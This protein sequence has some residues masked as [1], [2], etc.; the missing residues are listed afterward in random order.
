MARRRKR[1]HLNKGRI[2]A[3]LAIVVVIAAGVFFVTTR[4]GRTSYASVNKSMGEYMV[5]ANDDLLGK[6]TDKEL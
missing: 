2:A 6:G 4:L 3:L 5:K 1:R